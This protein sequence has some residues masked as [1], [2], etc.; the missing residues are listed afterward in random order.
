MRLQLLGHHELLPWPAHVEH[1]DLGIR[2]DNKI[3]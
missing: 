2:D 3:R 1:T